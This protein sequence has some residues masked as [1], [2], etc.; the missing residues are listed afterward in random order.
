MR[1]LL[2]STAAILAMAGA[3]IAPASA[4]P[5]RLKMASTYPS[6]L[7][8][9]GT[10]GKILEKNVNTASGGEIEIK[11]FEPG[12]LVP[13]LEVF[14]AIK[15]G[16][17]DAGWSTPGYWQG[18]EPALALFAAVPFGPS[19][20]EYGGWLLTGGGEDLMNEIYHK[21]NIHSLICGV[22]APEA[23]GWFREP[24]EN[25]DQL[26]GK[27]MR[28]FGLGARVMQKLG[29]DTQLLAA[30]DIYPALERG[31]IDATE[32]SQPAI[33]LNLGFYQVAK[34]YYFPGWHQQSTS[35]E[36]MINKEKWDAMTEQQQALLTMAC[37]ANYALGM[38]EGEAIQGAALKE[39]ESKGVTL[40]RWPPEILAQYEAAWNEVAAELAA[41]DASFKKAWDSLQAYR[42]DY[43]R[44]GELGYL[45]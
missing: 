13:A 16:S 39:L 41:E 24:V 14:D 9:L 38:A 44:W 29:V 21:H 43:E 33:D 32:F 30:A 20:G 26:K 42:S 40:H 15:N 5:V 6:S 37:R 19:A 35:F 36:L 2:I 1:K 17:V 28:F 4:E 3:A 12:A 10:L 27:K 31:T 11:F 34:H 8:Q 7:T 45:K 22:I 18:K 25:L 23:S